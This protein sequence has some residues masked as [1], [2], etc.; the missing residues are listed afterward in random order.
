MCQFLSVAQPH[1]PRLKKTENQKSFTQLINKETLLKHWKFYIIWFDSAKENSVT[2][3]LKTRHYSN[4]VQGEFYFFKEGKKRGESLPTISLCLLT[5]SNSTATA[6]QMQGHNQQ[7]L[8]FPHKIRSLELGG[9]WHQLHHL[10]MPSKT[11]FSDSS[12]IL[13]ICIT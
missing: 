1:S 11:R 7:V 10:M 4:V 2:L 6:I 8:G 12:F 9:C 13:R 5:I 3:A